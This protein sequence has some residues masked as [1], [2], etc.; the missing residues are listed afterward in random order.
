MCEL[1]APTETAI[2]KAEDVLSKYA[3]RF[4]GQY[5]ARFRRKLCLPV[6][7]P[8]E[9]V[10]ECLELLN[11][12]AIDFTV[13]FRCLT[14]V[15]DGD[16]PETLR[17]LFKDRDGFDRWWTKWSQEVDAV[18]H[19]ADMR[20]ANPVRIPRNHRVEQAIQS[21]YGGEFEPFH[22]LVD[23]LAEPYTDHEKYADLEVP[24]TPEEVVRETFC[25]T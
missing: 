21:A 17:K 22:R 5:A 23:A 7:A 16:G 20:A 10:H 2:K 19:L 15:A 1:R 6:E 14:Q 12:Q 9:L 8:V 4:G 25:G 11:A 18:G 13:F 3:E 24:P